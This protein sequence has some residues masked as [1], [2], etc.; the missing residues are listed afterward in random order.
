MDLILRQARVRGHDRPVDIGVHEGLVT[1]IAPKISGRPRQVIDCAGKI[2]SPP[3][4]DIH[5]LRSATIVGFIPACAGVT[6]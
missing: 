6:I 3:F 4:T 2:I 5:S 1:K